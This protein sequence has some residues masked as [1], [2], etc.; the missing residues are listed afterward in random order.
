MLQKT[1]PFLLAALLLAS[2]SVT[3][4]RVVDTRFA[5]FSAYPDMWISTNDCPFE[6]QAVGLLNIYITP[7]I[8]EPARQPKPKDGIYDQNFTPRTYATTEKLYY[9]DL[10]EYAVEQA[11]ARGANGISNFDVDIKVSQTGTITEYS[12]TALLI[13]IE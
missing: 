12:V 3:R 4:P 11:R 5:D 6:H 13:R 7:A 2:C 1:V 10:L 8:V 9:S